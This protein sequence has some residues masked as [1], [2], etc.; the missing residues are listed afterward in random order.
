MIPPVLTHC[1]SDE[2][3]AGPYVENENEKGRKAGRRWEQVTG[4]VREKR[5]NWR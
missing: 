3:A 4:G 2:E 5:E 1:D